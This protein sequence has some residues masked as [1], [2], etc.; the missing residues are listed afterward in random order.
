MVA[1]PRHVVKEVWYF[2]PFLHYQNYLVYRTCKVYLV[3]QKMLLRIHV[4]N[5]WMYSVC[6]IIAYL[7]V[8]MSGE[9]C[10]FLNVS[11]CVWCRH[12]DISSVWKSLVAICVFVAKVGLQSL[13]CGIVFRG[14]CKY[15]IAET[16]FKRVL[17]GT[18]FCRPPLK[19]NQK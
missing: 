2:C 1:T 12:L 4:Y 10:P 17:F 9:Y 15:C 6:S 7:E 5:L 3:Q 8:S 14:T 19:K 18:W 16:V 13:Q 11:I